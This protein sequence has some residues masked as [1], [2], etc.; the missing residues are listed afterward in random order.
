MKPRSDSGWTLT[1]R[2]VLWTM[3]L[4]AAPGSGFWGKVQ[5]ATG[6]TRKAC[7]REIYK[8][9][10]HEVGR[11]EVLC[12]LKFYRK[13]VTPLQN[14]EGLPFTRNE[15]SVLRNSSVCLTTEDLARLLGRKPG[16][17]SAQI[18]LLRY[19]GAEPLFPDL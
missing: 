15:N 12:C 6:R 11:D 1:E 5:K 9:H 14:R 16:S 3:F 17:V 13:E 18:Q 8:L 4:E 7:Q 10:R 2:R 19:G